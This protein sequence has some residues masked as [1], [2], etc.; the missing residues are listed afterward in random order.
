MK[1]LKK[2]PYLKTE[3]EVFEFWSTHDSTDY[4]DWSKAKRAVFP[5]LKPTTKLIS[6]RFPVPDLNRIK[7]LANRYDV[8][9]QTLIKNIVNRAVEKRLRFRGAT[10]KN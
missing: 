10:I 2:I 8:P 1:K 5:N 6:I 3:D 4:V 9:Y 7:A